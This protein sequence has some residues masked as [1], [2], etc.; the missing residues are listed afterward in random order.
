MK[1]LLQKVNHYIITSGIMEKMKTA[2]WKVKESIVLKL[3]IHY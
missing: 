2:V 1:D 3:E